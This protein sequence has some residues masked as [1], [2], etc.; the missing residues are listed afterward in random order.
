MKNI[1]GIMNH[2]KADE[3]VLAKGKLDEYMT[4]SHISDM[5]EY[6]IKMAQELLAVQYERKLERQSQ[7]AKTEAGPQ[8]NVVLALYLPESWTHEQSGKTLDSDQVILQIQI[9]YPDHLFGRE[10][11]YSRDRRIFVLHPHIISDGQ[12]SWLDEMRSCGMVQRYTIFP[13]GIKVLTDEE[14]E[15]AIPADKWVDLPGGDKWTIPGKDEAE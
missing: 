2:L 9:E 8:D 6:T 12:V 3:A 14:K 10:H 13:P 11:E 4:D 1:Q 5:L 15:N 7:Q